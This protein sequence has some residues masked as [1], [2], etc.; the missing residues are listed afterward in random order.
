MANPALSTLTDNFTTAAIN[1]AK[2]NSVTAGAAT[3]DTTNDLIVLAVPTTS[4]ATNSFG[5][6]LLFDAT[7]SSVYAEICAAPNGNGGTKTVMKVTL[8]ANN[9]VSMRLENG[10]FLLRVQTAG[11][12]VDT[13][14][15]TYNPYAHRWWRLRESVG[16][17]YAEA[18]PDGLNWT[19]LASKTYSWSATAVT[20]AFQTGANVTEAS[21]N[22]AT[23]GNINTRTGGQF[24]LNW[25][26]MEYGWGPY[27]GAN[28]GGAPLDRY[29][30]VTDRTEGTSS[31]QR[32]RQYETDQVRSAEASVTLSNRDAALDPTNSSSPWAGHIL[33]YQPYR[34][35]AQ[36]P[37]SRNLLDQVAATGGDLGGFSGTIV[38]G[39]T[40]IFS[41][42]DTTG[43]SFVSTATAWMGSTAMQFAVPISTAA[44]ARPC[45]TPR[46]SVIPGQTYTVQLRVRDITASTSLDVKAFIGWYTIG[47]GAPT[48]FTYGTTSTLTGSTTA[49]WTYLTVTATAPADAAGIDCGV[50]TASTAAAAANIQVD[51]WQL[52]KGSVASAWT[53]PGAWMPLY[54]GWTERWPSTWEMD[55]TYAV[56]EPTAVDTFSLLS[57]RQLNDALTMEINSSGGPRFLYKL[58]DPAGSTSVAD[59]T[60]NNPPVQI[61]ISKYGAGSIT[62]GTS[63]TATDTTN[64]IY[65]GSTGTVSTIA[66]SNPG[67]GVTSGGASFLKLSSAGIIGPADL[68]QWSRMFAFRYTGPMPSPQAVIWSSFSRT[69]SNNLPSGSQMW[70]YINSSGYLLLNMGGPTGSNASFQPSITN[71]VA[72]GD[73]HLVTVSYSRASAQLIINLDG[74]S[75][76]WSG[77]NPALEPSDLISDNI[78]SWVD[79]TVANG[80]T[81]NF[82]GDLAFVAEYPSALS[83]TAMVN[84]YS[85]WRSACAGEST[86]ARYQRILRYAGYTGA[87][88]TQTGLTTSMGPASI[89]GQDALTALQGVV[90]TENGAHFVAT[91][92]TV[93]FRSR[94]ARYNALTPMY[95]FGEKPELG[96]WPYEDCELD[97][98]STHLSNEVTVT[99]EGT[100]QLFY[101]SDDTSQ[102]AYFPRT[103]TRTINAS[104]GDECQDAANYLLSRYRQPATRVSSLKLHPSGNPA[105]WLV[106]LSLDLGTRIRV[107]RRP[108]GAPAIQIE[109]FVENMA[110]ELDD[111]NEAWLTLQCSPADL[112][113][114]GLFAAWHT[115]IASSVAVGAS[116][117]TINAPSG[118]VGLLA[119]QQLARGQQ[120]T[121]GQNTANAETVTVDSVA[122]TSVGWTTAVVTLAAVTTKSHAAGD[123]VCEPLPAG[124]T[125]PATWDSAAQFDSIAFAY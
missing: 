64:G 113:P 18:S 68:S 2:W 120:L 110:W 28:N 56:V 103:M 78:G 104:S 11:S 53:C 75:A 31:V 112:T 67:T 77:F 24:N 30:E 3:L 101:A 58:D 98:D 25:P 7:S 8:D 33:P 86:N 59:W 108:Q 76:F 70:W 80:A 79:P 102:S 117:I 54:Q 81:Y 49:G 4:G 51:G 23:L 124:T 43:G 107:M 6:T 73:W 65:T 47:T 99:Q 87:W 15:A 39:F 26:R 55:G 90:D 88:S 20:F 71:V 10:V 29:I 72:D 105:L 36:W 66:N 94:S 27:W 69:R 22:V 16:T 84:I 74:V 118:A 5:S 38:S 106:C 63:I 34:Q 62:F 125:D 44:N 95:T 35:R 111:N 109:C 17:W 61:G 121:L 91:D 97:F 85:A 116:S 12:N 32:G 50:A 89:D 40:D 123:T 57:Q 122:A 42:T 14:L 21:G 37:P 45:H 9:S 52:E 13:T 82:Q 115:T 60:G 41:S 48:S 46:Y 100:Q 19:T 83:S 96:E 92:G 114:Y 1:T 93:V 119:A